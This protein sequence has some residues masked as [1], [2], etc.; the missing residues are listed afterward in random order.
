MNMAR[1]LTVALM[2]AVLSGSWAGCSKKAAVAPAPAFTP[3][4]ADVV[5]TWV[6]ESA[7][8]EDAAYNAALNQAETMGIQPSDGKMQAQVRQNLA[9]LKTDPAEL[10]FKE[11]GVAEARR[12]GQ[13]GVGTR[14]LEGDT[15]TLDI[16]SLG[17]PRRF[18]VTAGNLINLP[19]IENGREVLLK[20]T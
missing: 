14:K 19:S 12:K 20:R 5:G 15:L 9:A 18:R 7:S 2:L 1:T 11:G 17:K 10:V 3:T 6:V 8:L 16:P 13:S 4:A